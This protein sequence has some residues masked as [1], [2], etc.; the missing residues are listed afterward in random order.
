MEDEPGKQRSGSRKG[1]GVRTSRS[2]E[3]A[4]TS[5]SGSHGLAATTSEGESADFSIEA[6]TDFESSNSTKSDDSKGST[7]GGLNLHHG[8]NFKGLKKTKS[9][10]CNVLQQLKK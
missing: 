6:H 4:G 1:S 10:V 5:Q 2:V 3:E 8:S 7:G 9:K